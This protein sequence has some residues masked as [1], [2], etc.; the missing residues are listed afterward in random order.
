VLRTVLAATAT[1]LSLVSVA[2]P[3]RAMDEPSEARSATPVTHRP[4]PL[5]DL[6]LRAEWGTVT[7]EAGVLRRG[8][9]TY[10]YSYAVTP[11]D[12]IWSLEVFISGPR[13][14]HLAA[15]AFLGGYDPENG[16]GHYTLCK[17]TTRYGKFRIEGKLS[18]DD[19]VGNIV[20]GR[21][22]MDTYLLHAPGR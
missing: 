13:L 4:D 10:T 9:R 5:A 22:P 18:I 12:G 21:L 2:G 20:E 16:V 8:C 1:A 14:K 11:P 3:A 6:P 7:G 19:G 17:V 15:G